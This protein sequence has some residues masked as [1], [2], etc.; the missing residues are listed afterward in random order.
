MS[1]DRRTETQV[2]CLRPC[3]DVV[4]LAMALKR[5]AQ[6]RG[7]D[8]RAITAA[9]V[10]AGHVH[11]HQRRSADGAPFLTHPLQVATLVCCW[12]GSTEDV[13]TAVL[14]DTA[15]DSL[16]GPQETLDHSSTCSARPSASACRRSPSTQRCVTA[17]CARKT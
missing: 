6:Q 4:L 8:V 10:L 13:V 2:S 3:S 15:E 1:N 12:G 17:T 11:R 14:H 5:A 16:A 7:L 9:V